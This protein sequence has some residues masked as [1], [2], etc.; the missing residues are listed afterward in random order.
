MVSLIYFVYFSS[1][2]SLNE[3]Q[4][5]IHNLSCQ[6]E[7]LRE[8]LDMKVWHT[9]INWRLD[10][11][12]WVLFLYRG[13]TRGEKTRSWWSWRNLSAMRREKRAN[14]SKTTSSFSGRWGKGSHNASPMTITPRALRG[15]LS[16]TK[17][18]YSLHKYSEECKLSVIRNFKTFTFQ[19][20][21]LDKASLAPSR[22]NQFSSSFSAG[23]PH[24]IWFS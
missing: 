20:S 3:S 2:T 17:G 22:L 24:A 7:N 8:M 23:E 16:Q 21:T 4:N 1:V 5:K 10:T 15:W 14:F 13:L 19:H 6:V 11:K 18:K 9:F 12:H